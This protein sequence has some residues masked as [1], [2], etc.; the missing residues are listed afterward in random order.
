LGT[1][2]NH[3]TYLDTASKLQNNIIASPTSTSWGGCA[4]EWNQSDNLYVKTG[5]PAACA[6]AGTDVTAGTSASLVLDVGSN[7]SPNT[8]NINTWRGYYIGSMPDPA[9]AKSSLSRTGIQLNNVE[10]GFA[11]TAGEKTQWKNILKEIPGTY[12]DNDGNGTIDDTEVQKFAY[13]AYYDFGGNA[14]ANTPRI[15]AWEIDP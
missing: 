12:Y 10:C 5:A 8:T 3:A 15:G 14:R 13:C 2:N 9:D 6:N 11:D 4:S 1:I 7:A